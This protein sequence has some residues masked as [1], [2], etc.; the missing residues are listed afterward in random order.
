MFFSCT[1]FVGQFK[2]NV[3]VFR[4]KTRALS[5]EEIKWKVVEMKKDGHSNLTIIDKLR[6]KDPTQLKRYVTPIFPSPNY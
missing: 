2:F 3:G 6:I 1:K 4:L 5:P